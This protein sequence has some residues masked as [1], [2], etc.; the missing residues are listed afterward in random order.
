MRLLTSQRE[1][2]PMMLSTP[3]SITTP[4]IKSLPL[5]QLS[6]TNVWLKMEALQP[7]GSFK[8]RG[9][10]LA[11]Q[12]HYQQ[13]AKRFIT[14]SGG[15]AGLSVAY[16][17]LQLGVEV[18]VVVPEA[19]SLQ[20][21]QLLRLHGAKVT[22]LGRSWSEAH[23]YAL[24]LVS[25]DD[26][27]IHPFDDPLLWQGHAA[28]IDEV[29]AAGVKPDAVVLSVGGGGLLAGV[30]EGLQ[31]NQLDKTHVFAVETSGM[32]SY[33]A[34]LAAGK[35]VTLP[36]VTGIATSLGARQVC[37]QAFDLSKKQ[38][39]SASTVTDY[40]AVSACLALLDEHRILVE[41]ACGAALA[42]LYQRSLELQHYENV[43]VIVCGGATASLKALQQFVAQTENG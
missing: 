34:A 42:A 3:L 4:L 10:G 39:V 5:S 36:E 18:C 33:G 14:S 22:V 11:C 21:Q 27:F 41:P 2:N 40:Q 38:P 37:Q 31:R 1:L 20:A 43:L 29:I 6:D 26:A 24:S 25:E 28:M 30:V 12:H 15:N 16:S 9:V 17:G 32:A 13:G 19:A 7:S 23:A 8:L 35:P